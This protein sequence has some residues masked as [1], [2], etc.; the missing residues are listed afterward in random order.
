MLYRW[1]HEMRDAIDNFISFVLHRYRDEKI[2][3][4]I[5]EIYFS[6]FGWTKKKKKK[7]KDSFIDKNSR[8]IEVGAKWKIFEILFLR[9]TRIEPR[10]GQLCFER[11][12]SNIYV[13]IL[14]RDQSVDR[15]TT[16]RACVS[17]GWGE[18]R[19]RFF[20]LSVEK[21]S[22]LDK[23]R[24]SVLGWRQRLRTDSKSPLRCGLDICD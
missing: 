18:R 6:F 3:E 16:T 24:N 4:E 20:N 14:R 19:R 11:R 13:S 12:Q 17:T 9:R 1:V 23:D 7:K 8:E 10:G 15:C 22:V 21:Q 2:D 5:C